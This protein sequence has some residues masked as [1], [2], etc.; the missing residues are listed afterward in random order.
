VLTGNSPQFWNG[1][2]LQFEIAL[3]RG[4]TLADIANIDSIT[5]DL[6]TTDLRTGL[7]LMS[8]TIASAD[9]NAAL[10]QDDW[11]AGDPVD[12]HALVK[13]TNGET[14]LYMVEDQQTFWLVISALTNDSPAHKITLGATPLIVIEDGAGVEPPASVVQPM[15]Y[16][17][18]QS[19]A[20]YTLSVDLSTINTHL[21]TLDGQVSAAQSTANAALPKAGGTM[22]GPLTITGLS[23]VL[24]AAA[25]LISG[26]ASTSDL[27][28]GSNLYFT[29]ARA[30]ARI[31]ASRGAANG[32]CPLDAGSLVPAAYLPPLAISQSFVVASQSAMLALTAER[33]DV[34]IRTDLNKSFILATDSP[35]TLADWKELLTPASAVTSVNGQTGAVTLT[36]SNISEGG[37]LYYT[38][39][40]AKVDAIAALL[41]GFSSASGGVVSSGDSVL[42]ALGKLENRTALNDAKLTGSDRLKTDG[43]I[44]MTGLLNFSGTGH[45]GL[46]LNN[47]TSTQ[48][49][50]LSA[51]N[52]MLVY[53]TTISAVQIYNGTWQTLG[54][55]GVGGTVWLNGSGAPS[56]GAGN[57]GDYYLDTAS[58]DIS[59][60]S[61]GSWAVA[62]S[63]GLPLSGGTMTGTLT[64]TS[65]LNPAIN[66]NPGYSLRVWNSDLN[67]GFKAGTD[68]LAYAGFDTVPTNGYG[69]HVPI[70][71][72]FCRDGLVVNGTLCLTGQGGAIAND[73]S[74]AANQATVNAILAQL[75]AIKII[76]P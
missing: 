68:E 50:A 12:C 29:N 33:G 14:N 30:D 64:F 37:N 15:Y 20:R 51:A 59:L 48:V 31:A 39:A 19:D 8:Q 55:G 26:G 21:S 6:K 3:F 71:A 74:G 43:S 27:V 57:N 66:F 10:T 11:N 13:F 56:G 24:K 9:L 25:G 72:L 28:E 18:A 62:V 65:G 49:A 38:S 75:R 47:L 1:V 73:A 36:T 69:W 23:G 44:A 32:I 70:G 52:G 35:V 7:P 41:T 5:V 40:R 45:A 54:G 17:A 67:I 61:G 2:D 34:A 53:N 42:A 46:K 60:K 4:A 63:H 58:Q 22:T 16:T 76:A